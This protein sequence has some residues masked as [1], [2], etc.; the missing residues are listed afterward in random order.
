M[1]HVFEDAVAED[2]DMNLHTAEAAETV[3]LPRRKEHDLTADTQART[4]MIAR[5][6]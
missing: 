3:P 5:S 6:R 4:I 2:A 1:A